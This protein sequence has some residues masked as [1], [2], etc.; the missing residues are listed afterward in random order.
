MA[1]VNILH[2]Y[3]KSTIITFK[4]GDI[5][6]KTVSIKGRTFEKCNTGTSEKFTSIK[7]RRKFTLDIMHTYSVCFPVSLSI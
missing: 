4:D 6:I 2:L 1:L 5:F 7:D 3:N